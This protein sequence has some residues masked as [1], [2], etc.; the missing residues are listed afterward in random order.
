MPN[1]RPRSTVPAT[2]TGG[3]NQTLDG[4]GE[5]SSNPTLNNRVSQVSAND[6]NDNDGN[7]INDDNELVL[8]AQIEVAR[9]AEALLVAEV[10]CL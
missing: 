7:S 10:D 1:R 9:E 5:G 4:N 6:Y 3:V 8:D 2:Q